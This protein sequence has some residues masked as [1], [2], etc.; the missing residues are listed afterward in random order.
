MLDYY[1]G[2]EDKENMTQAVVTAGTASSRDDVHM[3]LKLKGSPEKIMFFHWLMGEIDVDWPYAEN[4]RNK[5]LGVKCDDCGGF[6]YRAPEYEPYEIKLLAK[7][8]N[9]HPR[10]KGSLVVK[11]KMFTRLNNCNVVA[12]VVANQEKLDAQSG[13]VDEVN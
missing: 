4:R 10:L 2:I 5:H 13:K 9:D 1:F 12:A 8:I 7:Q 11:I 6:I 3:K